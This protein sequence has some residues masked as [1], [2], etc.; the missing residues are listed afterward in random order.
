MSAILVSKRPTSESGAFDLVRLLSMSWVVMAHQFGMRGG[1]SANDVID[2][3]KGNQ[4]KNDWNVTFIEHGYYAVD[5]FLFMGGYVAILSLKRVV[6]EFKK[7][8]MWKFP[9][10]YIFLVIKRYARIL[11]MM[12]LINLFVVYIYPFISYRNPTNSMINS[13]EVPPMYWGS[14]SLFYAWPINSMVTNINASWFWYLVV[15][16]QCFL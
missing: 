11:P 3:G 9:I 16:F 7:S 2:T 5:F 4:M 14:W 13:G 6:G 8:P 10:L 1:A 12:A 15:D